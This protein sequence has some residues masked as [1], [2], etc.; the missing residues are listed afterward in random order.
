VASDKTVTLITS[1]NIRRQVEEMGQ[2]IT[3]NYLTRLMDRPLEKMV[4]LVVMDGAFIFAADLVRSINANHK[5]L[6]ITAKSYKGKESTG[7]VHIKQNARLDIDEDTRVLIVEDIIETGRTMTELCS[8]LKSNY[9]PKTIEV[10]TL[11]DKPSKREIPFEPT[12]KGFEVDG[13]SFVIGYGLDLEGYYR[14]DSFI[15]KV[16]D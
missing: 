7:L 6:F 11:L 15:S 9:A 2:Q 4:V 5:V 16:E 8:H 14:S 10:A 13:E 1:N 12:Y 3:G